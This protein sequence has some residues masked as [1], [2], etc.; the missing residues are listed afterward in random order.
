MSEDFEVAD[1]WDT[2][3]LDAVF[4]ETTDGNVC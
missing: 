3:D 1:C 2:N 4:L